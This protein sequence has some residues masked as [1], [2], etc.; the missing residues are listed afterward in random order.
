V[1]FTWDPRKAAANVRKHGVTFEE[2][3]TVFADPLALLVT[4]A[5]E[6]DR[7]ILIGES[8]VRRVLVTVFIEIGAEEAR[9]VSARRATKSERRRYEEGQEE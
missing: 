8:V 2:A 7:E 5:V 6:A 9:I 1:R 3:V 4:D